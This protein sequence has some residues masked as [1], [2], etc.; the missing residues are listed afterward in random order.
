MAKNSKIEIQTGKDFPHIEVA[1]QIA[2]SQQQQHQWLPTYDVPKVRRSKITKCFYERKVGK[3]LKIRKSNSNGEGF[4]HTEAA[5]QIARSQH[6]WLPKYDVP[7]ER[8]SKIT[9]CFFRKVR[10]VQRFENRSSEKKWGGVF[11]YRSRIP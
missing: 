4:S 3:W 9:K 2:R 10:K 6:Q 5:Y 8:R 1:Y 7:K 11:L